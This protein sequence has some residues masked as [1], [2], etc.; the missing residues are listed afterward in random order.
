MGGSEG[1]DAILSGSVRR[2]G[3]QGRMIPSWHGFRVHMGLAFGYSVC[4]PLGR[5]LVA[6]LDIIDTTHELF[7]VRAIV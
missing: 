1:W 7:S 5:G 6:D 2:Q 4:V 3:T